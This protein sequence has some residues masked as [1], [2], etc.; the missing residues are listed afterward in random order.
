MPIPRPTSHRSRPPISFAKSLM[1]TSRSSLPSLRNSPASVAKTCSRPTAASARRRDSRESRWESS[2]SCRRTFSASTFIA[3]SL[4]VVQSR[5]RIPFV[6]VLTEG[7]IL[8]AEL[9]QRVVDRDSGLDGLTPESYHLA[10]GEKLNEAINNAWNRLI[11]SWR[12]FRETVLA[13][14]PETSPATAE[15]RDSWLFPYSRTRLRT[16]APGQAHRDR[17]EVSTRSPI[18]GTT[19]PDPPGRVSRRI[20]IV[21][22]P[23]RRERRTSPHSMVQELLNQSDDHLWGFLSNGPA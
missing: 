22:S 10:E 12:R 19:R 15:T 16:S 14:H 7:S 21:V 3:E 5:R 13:K 17:R 4:E 9:L 8:P 6:T 2:R 23:A 20:S 18:H 11:G 1:D